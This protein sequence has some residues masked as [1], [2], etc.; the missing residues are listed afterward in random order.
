MAHVERE[1]LP[2]IRAAVF[3]NKKNDHTFPLKHLTILLKNTN[4]FIAEVLSIKTTNESKRSG[5]ILLFLFFIIELFT[6]LSHQQTEV[7]LAELIVSLVEDIM[8][9][10]L[11]KPYHMRT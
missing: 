2:S 5:S 1:D 9:Q 7:T 11:S 3:F 10:G 6:A 8:I 4:V